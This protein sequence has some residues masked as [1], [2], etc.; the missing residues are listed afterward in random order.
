MTVIARVCLDML[1]SPKSRRKEPLGVHVPEAI[2]HVVTHT[3]EDLRYHDLG[4]S[5]A[6]WLVSDGV[7]VNVVQRVLGHE[8]ASTTLNRYT[9][10]PDD[11]GK[12]VRAAFDGPT[13]FR[14]P[15]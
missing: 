1:R 7:P 15:G 11:Y 8:Q 3:V 2:T 14:S 4:H 6:T 9:H 10:T 13:P 12:R 5:Y